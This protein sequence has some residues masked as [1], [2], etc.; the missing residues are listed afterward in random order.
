MGIVFFE[1]AF[2]FE[3][4]YLFFTRFLFFCQFFFFA[5]GFAFFFDFFVKVFFLTLFFLFVFFG[6]GFCVFLVAS[7]FACFAGSLVFL[8]Q[9]FFLKKKVLCLSSFKGFE[10]VF[11]CKRFCFFGCGRFFMQSFFF[12]FSFHV[13]WCVFISKGFVFFFQRVVSFFKNFLKVFFERKI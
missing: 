6:N 5:S 11:F 2:L 8:F 3:R 9:G 13:K 7:V 10:C 12:C 1:V 4:V